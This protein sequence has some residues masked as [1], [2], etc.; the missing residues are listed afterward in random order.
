MTDIEAIAEEIQQRYALRLDS[1]DSIPMVPRYL[2]P[3]RHREN[4]ATAVIA[5]PKEELSARRHFSAWDSM[6]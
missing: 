6:I 5:D 3:C 4:R 2:S 1:P